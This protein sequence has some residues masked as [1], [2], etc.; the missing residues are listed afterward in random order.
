[1]FIPFHSLIPQLSISYQSITKTQQLHAFVSKTHLSLDP[2]F[3]TRVVRF[4]ALNG[5][6]ASAR[7]LFD[8]MPKRSVFLWNSIIRAY[9]RAHEFKNAFSL[10]KR[11]FRSETKPDNF[12]FACVLRACSE[13]YDLEGVRLAHGGLVVFGLGM[14]SI[15]SSALVSGYSKLGLVDEASK[16]FNRV[17]APDLAMWNSMISGYGYGGF[18]GDGL[19]L[20]NAMRNRGMEPDGYTMVG[21]LLGLTDHE[22]LWIGQGVHGFCIKTS[23]DYNAHV[24][25]SLVS[26]YSR[27]NCLD[28][29]HKVF[30]NMLMPDLVTWSSLITGFSQSGDTRN[31]LLFFRK[32]NMEG[33]EADP[34]L[35]ACALAA[36]AQLAIVELGREL[37][38]YVLRRALE[39]N[40]MVSSAVIDMYSKCGFINS[41]MRFF[42]SL[43]RRNLVTYNSV[44]QGLGSHGLASQSFWIFNQVLENG[45]RP[46]ESTFSALLHACCHAGLVKDGKEV[47]SRMQNE[48]GVEPGTEH[49]VHMVKLLGM[50][51]E[52]KEAYNLVLSLPEPIEDGIWGALLG[53]CETQGD[54]RFAENISQHIIE[55]KPQ[56]S[57]YDVTM[58]K[59]YANDGRWYEVEKLRHGLTFSGQR[60]I[61][62]I[63]WI[64]NSGSHDT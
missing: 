34:V 4:Y 21:M 37:H 50:A 49:Y 58:S 42:K 11:M 46:D 16:V 23:F 59:I 31:S 15:C 63:S 38:G 18:W 62:G 24:G 39:T 35:I 1:M 48:F 43:P 6:L 7:N 12:T 5:D 36:S 2:F 53:C 47:F 52:L 33:M 61:P 3:A 51:G 29:A 10:F 25:S 40:I 27:C 54:S 17:A 14:D 8:E 57:S 13:N 44:I 41:A 20:F 32:M 64:S 22:L 28:S 19:R 56:K 30:G 26:M 55:S 9:A 60:K 45:L